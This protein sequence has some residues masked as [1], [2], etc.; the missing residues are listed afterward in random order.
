MLHRQSPGESRRNSSKV[1]KATVWIPFFV[2]G[3]LWLLLG[4][5]ILLTAGFFTTLKMFLCTQC[6]S[7][8][9]PLNGVPESIGSTSCE[10]DPAIAATWTAGSGACADGGPT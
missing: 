3:G 1:A 5:Y 8:A 4:L 7:L 10:R 2:V 9:Y 6:M